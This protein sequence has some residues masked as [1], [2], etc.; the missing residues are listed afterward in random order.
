MRFGNWETGSYDRDAA[1]DL[2]N[3][4]VN[5]L[6]SVLLVSRG[7]TCIGDARAYLGEVP[8]RIHDPFLLADMDKAVSRINTALKHK[9]KIAVYGDYDVDGMT[10]SVLLALWL[11]ARNA[12]FEIYIPERIGEGYGL[13]ISAIDILKSHKVNLII[14]VDCGITAHDEARHAKELGLSLIITDHH[15]CR[16]EL[17]EA[18]AV[19][20]PKRHD[21]GYPNKA[22]AGV[23]VAFKLICALDNSEDPNEM[24][25]R[26]GDLVAIG[27]V[28][29]VMPLEGEN[30]ELIR[31]GLQVLN[32][33][34]R[35]GIARLLQEVCTQ[36]GKVTASTVGFVLAPRLNA[37]G[38]MRQTEL[39]IDLLL[40]GSAAEAE[41]LTIELCRLNSE[42]RSHEQEVFEQ[43]TEML[44]QVIP[45]GPI[46][47]AQRGWYQGVTGIVASK[48]AERYRTPTIIISIDDDGI[49]RGSCRSFGGFPLYQAVLTCVDILKDYGG[50]E[51]AVGMTVA[52][53]NIEEL[54]LRLTRYFRESPSI[55]GV[56]AL[57][58]D[59]EVI[60]PELLTVEN[61]E[62]LEKLEPFGNGNPP[63]NLCITEAELSYAAAIG[64]G[65]HSRLRFEKW[66]R[67]L[68]G[69]YFS[70]APGELGVSEGMTVDVAFEPQI[71]DYRGR[72]SVQLNV[73]DIKK[74]INNAECRMQ[75]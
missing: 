62:A 46:I 69:I 55:Y 52:E 32:D 54:K 9:E 5:P 37:A 28:A 7:V 15:E 53:E 2:C 18:D 26:Y 71:N 64:E 6:V 21:C 33:S 11:Q 17:P 41:M 12:D 10:S 42:R 35:P 67:S 58:L 49:G 60:K 66:G 75:N 24:L 44:Q 72:K 34:K 29:D 45:E 19:V 48:M 65:K 57:K 31:R 40:T 36:P 14:T 4:G 59:F 8:G 68:D 61:L 73:L 50:H 51:L 27:T 56:P 13:N 16:G 20:D 47:L 3:H 39:A 23:G 30:R 63:P 43:A 22:L 38:R 74:S 70:M 25:N 1:V